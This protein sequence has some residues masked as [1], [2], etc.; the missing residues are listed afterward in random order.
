M[1][2]SRIW[3]WVIAAIAML[4][5][6]CGGGGT[7]PTNPDN[8]GGGNNPP[9]EQQQQAP[10]SVVLTATP[11]QG[12]APLTVSFSA[13][14]F[15]GYPSYSYEWDFNGDGVTDSN[16]VDP[17]WTY[18]NSGIAKVTITDSHQQVV[19]VQKT[20]TVTAPTGGGGGT[21]SPPLVVRFQ[22]SVNAGTAPLR[23]QFTALVSG[24]SPPY[25][26]LW[27]F[28][29]DGIV[30]S[31]SE[32]PVHV[33]ES[34][35]PYTGPG[36]YFLYPVLTVI[37]N[38]GVQVSTADDLDGDGQSDWR[39]A[40]NVM[41]PGTL[42]AYAAVNPSSGQAPLACVFSGGAS[43]GEPPYTFAWDFG[44]GSTRAAD[45]S[46]VATHTYSNTGT[47]YALLTVT[48]NQG[49]TE[50]SGIV[51]VYVSQEATFNIRI[52]ADATTGPVPF[53]VQ[54]TSFVE[55]GREPVNYNWEV[56][57]DLVPGGDEP[58][59]VLP[60]QYPVP[61]KSQQAVVVP[62]ITS[63]PNP[64]ITF[65]T[66]TGQ[67]VDLNNNGAYD[68]GEAVGAPYVVRLVAKDA[69]GVETV[70]NL[71]RIN[72]RE[73]M[74]NTLYRA[75]RSPSVGWSTY[76]AL[77]IS[78]LPSFSARS[79]PAT[80]AH[81][82]GMV[83]FFGGDTYSDTG[84]FQGIVGL[85]ESSWALNLTGSDRTPTGLFGS[86]GG[87]AY[88]DGGFTL[89]NSLQGL[90]WAFVGQ[91]PTVKTPPTPGTAFPPAF[92][93][94]GRTLQKSDQFV[95]RGSSA[96]AMV[97]EQW[98]TNPGGFGGTNGTTDIDFGPA[99]KSP[100]D[101]NADWSLGNQGLGVPVIYVFGGRDNSGNPLD[102]VQKYYPETYGTEDQ[103]PIT[104]DPSTGTPLA[105]VVNGQTDIWSN[106]YMMVD[107]D[108]LPQE[109]QNPN[110][111]MS[112]DR[113]PMD[114]GGGGQNGAVSL[115]PMPEPLYGLAAVTIEN[116]GNISPPPV[117]PEG[118]FNYIFILG[119]I[120][121]GGVPVAT[122]R[123][124]N[125]AAPP[126]RRN[127]NQDPEFG[128]Y[129]PVADMPIERA[130][131]KAIVILGDKLT[132]KKWKIVVFGG[133]DRNGNYISQIDEFTFTSVT[134]PT[135]GSWS[136]I[137][138]APEAA[139]GLG[140]G[141]QVDARGTVY[142]QFG[143][144]TRDGYTGSVYDV[145]GGGSISLSPTGL[146]PR[147]WVGAAGVVA[148]NDFFTGAGDYYIVGGVTPNGPD[149][150]VEHYR[151]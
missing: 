139:A 11:D 80:L 56:F 92:M 73:S 113:P 77:G 58:V 134:A 51:P 16:A 67:Y 6:G 18:N 75:E 25:G 109:G 132:N 131:H 49:V 123:L 138:S 78:S 115:N 66:F 54:F 34:P 57:T 29:G 122:M 61:V 20:I 103:F 40:I 150:I 88:A 28:N 35:G 107:W 65:G 99:F 106:R 145:L 53:N 124:F 120:N 30:D 10:F 90:A 146:V 86:A 38:R 3:L 108:W 127:E 47:Y 15:G 136:T 144:R 110:P 93:S 36:Q 143:G 101:G 37:D 118:G 82:S 4:V 45:A 5:M 85:T 114:G 14:A 128:D 42:S 125:A 12:A 69:N 17:Y 1:L 8:G 27:D 104:F 81:P 23:V 84:E 76:A 60:P 151:P 89:L 7:T 13:Y 147:G 55:G 31:N 116:N 68:A 91:N 117:W 129:S 148:P 70:S 98:D 46:A 83:Y 130:Y 62:N 2:R 59:I 44:D 105:Q 19:T 111:P 71:I 119:G 126:G 141:W 95:P 43:G 121:D 32:N 63:E 26:F 140:A 94:L 133:F 149:T 97:H 79:N 22:P 112:P 137:G 24:G 50:T 33:F 135:T 102:T 52:E 48:D 74:P 9:P 87:S 39:V 100:D 142:K 64:L 41:P 21:G 96:A 72:P